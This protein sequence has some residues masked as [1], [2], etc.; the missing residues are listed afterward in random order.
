MNG[1]LLRIGVI[2]HYEYITVRSAESLAATEVC[3]SFS[4]ATIRVS[5]IGDVFYPQTCLII[6]HYFNGY[7]TTHMH[8]N[9]NKGTLGYP[10]VPYK[11]S[12]KGM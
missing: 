6:P 7:L 8:S 2:E 1:L 11:G 5:G 10:R 3:T 12:T 9:M 4:E